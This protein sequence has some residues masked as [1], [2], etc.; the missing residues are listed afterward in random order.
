MT[1]LELAKDRIRVNVICPGAIA[2]NIE[3]STEKRDVERAEEPHEFPAGKV[4]LTDGRPG[5]AEQVAELVLFLASAR[6]SGH[7]TG[8][9]LWI[10][11]AESLLQ[12]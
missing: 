10:D 12:G 11:G 2:S 9:P 7:I 5:T 4:P 1:A 3:G 8:T 6:R